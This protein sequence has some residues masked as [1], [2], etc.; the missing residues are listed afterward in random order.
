MGGGGGEKVNHEAPS[1]AAARAKSKILAQTISA[2]KTILCGLLGDKLMIL[3]YRATSGPPRE[4]LSR[5]V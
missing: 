2:T 3:F 1:E 5:Q 4:R